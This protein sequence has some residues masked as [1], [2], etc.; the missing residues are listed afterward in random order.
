VKQNIVTL[1]RILYVLAGL[2]II[3]GISM[4]LH[5]RK[6]PMTA[7]PVTQPSAS[8]YKE[9]IAGAGIIE[10]QTENIQLGS[11]VPGIVDHVFVKVG[12][13][14]KKGH[15]LFSLDPRQ[16]QNELQT[17]LAQLDKGKASYMQTKTTLKDAQD[18]LTFVKNL[19]DK[20]AISKEELVT[21]RNAVL[22]AEAN[23]QVAAAEVK[24]SQAAVKTARTNLDLYVIK[25]PIDCSVLQINV[26]PGEYVPTAQLP[27]PLMIVG[28]TY[29]YHIRVDVDENDAWRFKS[30][31]AA[32][33]YLRGNSSIKIPLVFEYVE[34]YVVPK[35]NLTGA[36]TE[37]VDVRVLQVIYSYD[38]KD[39]PSYVGQQVDVYIEVPAP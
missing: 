25:A 31:T 29:N 12:D 8:P 23:L 33:A 9:F 15:S 13:S 32:I 19:S 11:L 24:S 35:K 21:R 27:N 22:L 36:S 1:N 14:V 4:V 17:Q 37:R 34:P 10:A 18:K 30:H 16:A 20:R 5:D 39:L 26:H 3:G 6:P 28:S 38:P 7:Q 2:G